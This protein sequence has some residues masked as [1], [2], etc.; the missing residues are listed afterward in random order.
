MAAGSYSSRR[1]W[2]AA[3]GRSRRYYVRHF[4]HGAWLVGASADT[5]AKLAVAV[6]RVRARY[7]E[8]AIRVTDAQGAVVSEAAAARA[9]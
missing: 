7:P 6:A 5:E 8:A 3:G 4:A 2:R 1:D 9:A